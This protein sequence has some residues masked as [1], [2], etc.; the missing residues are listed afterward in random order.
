VT[1]DD[2]YSDVNEPGA[3]DELLMQLRALGNGP[4]PTPSPE[5]E[6][7]FELGVPFTRHASPRRR[8]VLLV[9]AAAVVFAATV[10]PAAAGAL[11]RPARHFVDTVIHD[12][13]RF[14]ITPRDPAP[15][16]SPTLT[17]PPASSVPAVP[18]PLSDSPDPRSED[19][20]VP[21]SENSAEPQSSEDGNEAP[22]GSTGTARPEDGAETSSSDGTTTPRSAQAVPEPG[23]DAPSPG[24]TSTRVANAVPEP[25]ENRPSRISTPTAGSSRVASSRSETPDPATGSSS[26]AP[27]LDLTS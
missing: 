5:L 10:T 15:S 3:P 27:E 11:P 14:P 17:R 16:K 20:T 4:V 19:S 13:T 12:L 9:T 7:I 24:A 25:S 8:R 1:P 26:G 18:A 22:S 6:E 23:E 21:R 2:D